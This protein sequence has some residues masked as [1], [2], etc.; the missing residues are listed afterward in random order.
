MGEVRRIIGKFFSVK[1]WA[2]FGCFY[3]LNK[4]VDSGLDL[5]G[6][7]M[8]LAAAILSFMGINVLQDFVFMGTKRGG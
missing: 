2:G 7:D 1:L 3:L 8:I 4:L 6:V 5:G